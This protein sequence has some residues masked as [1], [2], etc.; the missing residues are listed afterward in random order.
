MRK[1]LKNLERGRVKVTGTPM[2][3]LP[4][5]PSGDCA[6]FWYEVYSGLCAYHIARCPI[7]GVVEP[8]KPT[9]EGAGSGG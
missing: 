7:M 9:V 2:L 4:P 3:G 5:V 6:F 1:G 8:M